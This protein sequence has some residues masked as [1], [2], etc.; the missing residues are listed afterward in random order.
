VDPARC[1]A[2]EKI[3]RA[4]KGQSRA[5]FCPLLKEGRA[6]SASAVYARTRQPKRD[7]H[8]D[9]PSGA[10]RGEEG[11]T[12]QKSYSAQ[13]EDWRATAAAHKGLIQHQEGEKQKGEDHDPL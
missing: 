2:P 8:R 5:L 1:W 13:Q 6:I 4:I 3:D 12:D 9:Q 7:D 10:G 11:K